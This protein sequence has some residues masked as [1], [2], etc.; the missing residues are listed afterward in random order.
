MKLWTPLA[1]ILATAAIGCGPSKADLR[2]A[3]R[4]VPKCWEPRTNEKP[5]PLT[6]DRLANADAVIGER[7]SR[8]VVVIY[9]R[10]KDRWRSY[11]AAK[12]M[13]FADHPHVWWLFGEGEKSHYGNLRTRTHAEFPHLPG[14]L[15]RAPGPRLAD[16]G[17]N[18]LAGVVGGSI[19]SRVP[20][21]KKYRRFDPFKNQWR[22]LPGEKVLPRGQSVLHVI[23]ADAGLTISL[24]PPVYCLMW[25]GSDWN[26]Y[27][28]P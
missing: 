5:A 2:K 23:D 10:R 20:S 17:M 21:E 12:G 14:E 4:T 9:D 1:I 28:Y 25:P 15:F 16:V 3:M 11:A 8:N 22:D 19:L 13:L 24:G 26:T 27:Q 18:A 7:Y 6:L